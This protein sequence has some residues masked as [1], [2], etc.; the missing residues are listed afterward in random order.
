LEAEFFGI[1]FL[2]I[3]QLFVGSSS[4]GDK[5]MSFMKRGTLT[6]ILFFFLALIAGI[7]PNA[8][9]VSK[10]LGALVFVAIL[11][12]SPG[13]DIIQSLDKFFKSDW[14]GTSESAHDTASADTGTAATSAGVIGTAEGA[15]SNALKGLTEI[16]LP[17]I[18]PVFGVEKIVSGLKGL[19][20]L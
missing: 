2:L 16:Q 6:A 10:G 1:I 14:V 8:A 9:K 15:A 5:M 4:Y 18:G 3:V 12:S 19:L 20:H 17:G 11:I 7:G 13:Q